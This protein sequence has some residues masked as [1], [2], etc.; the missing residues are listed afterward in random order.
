MS[1]WPA[2]GPRETVGLLRRSHACGL[3]RVSIKDNGCIY[4][5]TLCS[6]GQDEKSVQNTGGEQC[7]QRLFLGPFIYELSVT[8]R[9]SCHAQEVRTRTW[10]VDEHAMVRLAQNFV[11]LHVQWKLERNFCFAA[12]KFSWLH[13]FM[14][15]LM[16]WMGLQGHVQVGPST[17]S[18]SH[19]CG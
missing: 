19:A 18:L 9:A 4:I 5:H 8:Q 11:T 10:D 6:A 17:A 13:H 14:V 12:G 15:L 2:Q 1:A 3:S 16:T 7:L